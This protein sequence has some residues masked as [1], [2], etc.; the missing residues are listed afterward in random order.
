MTRREEQR[1]QRPDA[2]PRG[3]AEPAPAM[4]PSAARVL[5]LQRSAGN[6]AVA[7]ML[8][9]HEDDAPAT[10]GGA[11]TGTPAVLTQAGQEAEALETWGLL[12]GIHQEMLAH[13]DVRI[14]NTAQMLDPPA[15]GPQ[16]HRMSVKPMTLRS[17][18]ARL[19]ADRGENPAQ[20]AYF[21][22]GSRQDNEHKHGPTT[23]GTIEGGTT[24]IVRGRRSSGAWQTHERIMG[25]L[26][27]EC[28][29]ILV[30]D[31]GE[32]SATGTN[33]ASF[34]RYRDEFRAYFVEPHGNFEGIT[35]PTA[36][37]TAIKD[38]L[39]GTSAA[40]VSSYPE[41]HAAYW[42]QPLATNTFHQ[43]V[44]GH[45]RPDG[46]NLTNSP[47]LDRLVSLLREQ[48]AGR[49]GVE[50]TIFQIAV[51]SAAERQE[52]AGA[53][54]IATLLGRLDAAD[55]DRIR[56]TL[57]SPAAVGY[58]R[59]MNPNDSPRVTAFLSAVAAKAPDEIVT[60]YR[61]C[62]PQDRADLHFNE[63]VLSWIGV[64]LPNEM[65][66]RTCVICMITGRSFVYFDRVRVFA[67]SCSA[68]AGAGEMPEALRG[69]LRD[70]SLDVRMGY[71][72][73]CEDAYRVHVEPLQE[74]VR[75]QVRAILRGDAEP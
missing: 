39:V 6:R 61:A 11:A 49:A 4:A 74:P 59:E 31:Y 22:Y 46:F 41:L 32:H 23:L 40:V 30:K 50:D 57:T 35:D 65:L 51:L 37:A 69:A 66:M 72:R 58:G 5:A 27:H 52:A 12:R 19:V 2:A 43:Q 68:A 1:E 60:T 9:R 45:T 29:H 62:N 10:G 71:Y 63:H 75:R 13:T 47:R 54:L 16:G 44:D 55:A 20:D 26:V 25:A 3:A 15:E 21:F 48:R 8:A 7:G 67:Q 24:V 64:T 33:A 70:L 36:R 73:F 38:H 53:T 28:S 34:D 56:R 14:S 17:D 18:S 42:A